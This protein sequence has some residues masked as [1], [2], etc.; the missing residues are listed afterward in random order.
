[1]RLERVGLVVLVGWM[2]SVSHVSAHRMDEYLQATRVSIAVDRVNLEIDLTPGISIAAD[3]ISSIDTDAD[4]RISPAERAAHASGMLRSVVL[5]ADGRRMPLSLV[6]SEYPDPS[7]ITAGV[8]TVRLVATAEMA[9]VSP[10]RHIVSYVNAYRPDTSVY[11]ANA[12]VPADR[13]VTINSQRRDPAQRELTL[14]YDVALPAW[15]RGLSIA[16]G[17]G[18]VALLT[19]ARLSRTRATCRTVC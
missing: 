11:L 17:L 19:A 2:G 5:S 14:E 16:A 7:D 15:R 13:R 9:A 18:I 8:G 3:A 4:G 1:M 6:G 10:G 12:L